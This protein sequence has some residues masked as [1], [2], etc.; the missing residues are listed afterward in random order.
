[1]L[2]DFDVRGKYG[3]DFSLKEVLLRIMDL[4]F[5]QKWWLKVKMS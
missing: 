5:V 1:M 4:Y 2:V 3:M